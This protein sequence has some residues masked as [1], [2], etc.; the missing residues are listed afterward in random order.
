MKA[1]RIAVIALPVL[2]L[3]ACGDPQT[4]CRDGMEQ[5]K[6]RLAG[7]VG[8]REHKDKNSLMVQAHTH[9]DIAQ[10]MLAT[11]NYKGC[12]DKIYAAKKS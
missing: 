1:A 4:H 7:V 5:M 12:P 9:L 10:T 6:A 3:C 11:G 8:S 2:A